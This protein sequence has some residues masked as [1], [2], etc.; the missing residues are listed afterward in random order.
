MLGMFD[1]ITALFSVIY[2]IG[3]LLATFYVIIMLP[4]NPSD[5]P[6]FISIIHM[7]VILSLAGLYF[8]RHIYAWLWEQISK[9]IDEKAK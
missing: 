1:A 5:A 3:F 6:L 4:K 7:I 2:D 9:L 8:T